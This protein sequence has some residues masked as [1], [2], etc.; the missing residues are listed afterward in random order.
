MDSFLS[1]KL[2]GCVGLCLLAALL[3]P[4]VS[5]AEPAAGP[6]TV[7]VAPDNSFTIWLL[8]GDR[9]VLTIA[10]GGWGPNWAW[11]PGLSSQAKAANGVLDMTS[12]FVVDQAKAQVINAACRAE[13]MSYSRF[14]EGLAKAQVAVDRKMLADLAVRDPAAFKA[15]LEKAK[16]GLNA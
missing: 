15:V 6:W 13:G 7:L 1:A 16:S 8:Q 12:S 4:A 2:V 10:S 14:I 5:A 9:A 3:S 11:Q